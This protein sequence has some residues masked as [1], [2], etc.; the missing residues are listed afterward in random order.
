[1][2]ILWLRYRPKLHTLDSIRAVP[3][4]LMIVQIKAYVL[5]FPVSYLYLHKSPFPIPVDLDSFAHYIEN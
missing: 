3:F 2:L 4:K 1:M 5:Q